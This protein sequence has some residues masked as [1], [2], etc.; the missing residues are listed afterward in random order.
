MQFQLDRGCQPKSP[1][2]TFLPTFTHNLQSVANFKA[3]L[4]ATFADATIAQRLAQVRQAACNAK[5]YRPPCYKIGDSV[6]LSKKLFIYMPFSAKPC[7]KLCVQKYGPFN[8][9]EAIG[10]IYVCLELPEKLNIHP[11]IHVEHTSRVFEQPPD[12]SAIH[13]MP[14]QPFIDQFGERMIGVS[15]ILAYKQKERG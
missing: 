6:F 1:I 13:P 11:V 5:R 14:F 7:Q 2:D 8:I 9:L 12:I 15:K 4:K 3:K 10:K